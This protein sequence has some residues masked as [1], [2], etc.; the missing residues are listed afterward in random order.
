MNE[1]YPVP[2]QNSRKMIR[3]SMAL[4]A[5][6]FSEDSESFRDYYRNHVAVK[7]RIQ[8]RYEE[9]LLAS[10]VQWN[11]YTMWFKD[12]KIPSYYMVGV[13]TRENCRHRGYMTGLISDG[14]YRLSAE[15]VPFVDLM[16][17]DPAIYT[18]LGFRYIY[19]KAEWSGS[20]REGGLAAADDMTISM[21]SV[22]A[23]YET[24]FAFAA[25]WVNSRLKKM[26]TVFAVRDEGFMARTAAECASE[27]GTLAGIFMREKL[28]G[29]FS[30]WMED[31]ISIRDIV[32]DAEWEDRKDL[33]FAALLRY[34]EGED[35]IRMV[36]TGW[37]GAK[38]PIIMARVVNLAAFLAPFTSD[39]RRKLRIWVKDDLIPDNNGS[40]CWI[41]SPEGS[42]VYPTQREAD[43]AVDIEELMPWL[44]GAAPMPS[45]LPEECRS[46]HTLSG[47]YSPE[48][49]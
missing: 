22:R 6:V 24:E 41:V 8:T 23:L 19:E 11:P 5:V 10:M 35:R 43:G 49:V 36:T 14:L 3:D 40:F 16:P 42:M 20:L 17:A 44:L 28:V 18:P 27:G 48:I 15:K 13:A 37:L 9:G 38:K 4:W 2:E 46:I 30:W 39:E 1:R 47:V 25:G 29:I 12:R 33:L 21:M 45:M 32:L 31:G 34:F 7:N 26:F